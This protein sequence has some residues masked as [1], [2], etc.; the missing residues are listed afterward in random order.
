M[1]F[2][3][4]HLSS[5]IN[6]SPGGFPTKLL[7]SLIYTILTASPVC[8]N[9]TNIPKLSIVE[10]HKSLSYFYAISILN[11]SFSLDK[12]ISITIL[13]IQI[14]VLHLKYRKSHVKWVPCHYRISNYGQPIKDGHP[15]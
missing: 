6:L 5:Q 4:S 8:Y 11:I 12:N 15:A 1:S 3:C 10:A 13:L 9:L 2:F 14:Y 7:H